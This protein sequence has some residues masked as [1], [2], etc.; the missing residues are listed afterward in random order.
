MKMSDAQHSPMIQLG[1]DADGNLKMIVMKEVWDVLKAAA[2]DKP[3]WV[4]ECDKHVHIDLKALSATGIKSVTLM[5][6]SDQPWCPPIK[7]G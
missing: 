3:G 1:V 4:K 6:G 7:Q 2:N 5:A